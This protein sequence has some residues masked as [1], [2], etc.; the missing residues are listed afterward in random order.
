MASE[1]RRSID[2]GA[3]EVDEVDQGD[4]RQWLGHQQS[5]RS[6]SVPASTPAQSAKDSSMAALI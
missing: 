4:D 5:F 3:G 2:D 6:L 1:N